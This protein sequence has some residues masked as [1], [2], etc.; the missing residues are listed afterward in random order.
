MRSLYMLRRRYRWR[1]RVE[2][3]GPACTIRR[4]DTYRWPTVAYCRRLRQ[5][6]PVD[7]FVRGWRDGSGLEH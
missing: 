3:S 5:F 2:T 4:V 6:V 1:Y 7:A